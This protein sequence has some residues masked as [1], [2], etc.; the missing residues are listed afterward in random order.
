MLTAGSP[1]AEFT[2]Y[3]EFTND[4]E[5]CWSHH[6]VLNPVSLVTENSVVFPS[7]W[8]EGNFNQ[9]GHRLQRIAGDSHI[10]EVFQLNYLN[11]PVTE[12][13]ERVPA[14]TTSMTQWLHTKPVTEST[15]LAY[16]QRNTG[17]V[18]GLKL[19]HQAIGPS[20]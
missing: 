11:Q 6:P 10:Q 19:E 2:G 3:R 4:R 9:Q 12:P 16:R 17:E 5:I 20:K 13:A 18:T 8:A 14:H 1:V 7:L 15:G